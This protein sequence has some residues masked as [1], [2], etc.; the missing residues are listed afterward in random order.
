MTGAQLE[1]RLHRRW[2]DAEDAAVIDHVPAERLA[3]SRRLNRSISALKVR[4]CWL[5]AARRLAAGQRSESGG[6]ES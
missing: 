6:S 2:T 4:Q 5:R 1:R 3:L